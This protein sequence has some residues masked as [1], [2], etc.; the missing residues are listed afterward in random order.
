MTDQQ[1]ETLMAKQDELLAEQR[2]LRRIALWV[3]YLATAM[4][5]VVFLGPIIRSLT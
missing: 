2:A 1:F 3:L 4:F 5:V